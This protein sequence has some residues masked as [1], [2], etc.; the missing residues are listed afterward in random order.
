MVLND[1]AEHPNNCT[2]M[3]YLDDKLV[4]LFH[5]GTENN[6]MWSPC[7]MGLI[8]DLYIPVFGSEVV[9][10]RDCSHPL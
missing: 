4:L 7:T 5:K 10:Q 6:L 2:R 9:Y 1:I 3:N 8:L